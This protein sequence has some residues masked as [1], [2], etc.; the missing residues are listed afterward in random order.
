M[1][2]AEN[3]VSFGD[4]ILWMLWLFLLVVFFWLLITI[5]SDIWRDRE[6]SGGA[7][8]LWVIFVIIFPFLGIFIYLIVRGNDMTERAAAEQAR[9][10]EQIQE[11]AAAGGVAGGGSTADELAKLADLKEKGTISEA[12]YNTLKA[13]ALG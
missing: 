10:V 6:L 8:A 2:L 12:E 1:L 5:F 11:I 3:D 7:K 9:Q 4:V 13:K